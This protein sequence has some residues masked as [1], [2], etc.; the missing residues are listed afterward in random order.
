[1]VTFPLEKQGRIV[2]DILLESV[3]WEYLLTARCC[4]NLDGIWRAYLSDGEN[5]ILIGVMEP[6]PTGFFAKKRVSSLSVQQNHAVGKLQ[7]DKMVSLCDLRWVPC[8]NPANIFSDI[9]IQKTIGILI[10]S[11]ENP[12][13]IAFPLDVESECAQVLCLART[14]EFSGRRYAVLGVDSH[15]NPIT[16]K[17]GA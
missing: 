7:F 12:S 16:F 14:M 8:V 1:M 9:I 5:E 11:Q 6:N 10:D 3:G 15:G 17:G 13:R 2:G 4:E